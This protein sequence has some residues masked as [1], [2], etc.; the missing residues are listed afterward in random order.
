M[1]E[2]HQLIGF[3]HIETEAAAA[4]S[5][6]TNVITTKDITAATWKI[7]AKLQTVHERLKIVKDNLDI[8]SV[9]LN[10]IKV[11]NQL[12]V[13]NEL[14]S[15][16]I[17]MILAYMGNSTPDGWLDCNGAG[18]D[19]LKYKTLQSLI[20]NKTPDLNNRFI[21]GAQ[22]NAPV[23]DWEAM[24]GGQSEIGIHWG[25]IKSIKL[26]IRKESFRIK[27]ITAGDSSDIY[28]YFLYGGV[29]CMT[30]SLNIGT[31]SPDKIKIIPVHYKL[32]YIIKAH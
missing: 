21:M 7:K 26:T 8:I 29:R 17:G 15:H 3:D 1:E 22:V 9:D 6:Q 23:R 16:P 18:F 24:A 10:G 5:V 32:R 28:R 12:F 14:V 4:R 2:E 27:K 30:R 19:T 31:S 25:N 11:H 20:G 13:R